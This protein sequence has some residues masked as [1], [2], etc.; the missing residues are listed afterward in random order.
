MRFFSCLLSLPVEVNR[1]RKRLTERA[2]L[3]HY[4]DVSR[5]QPV[6]D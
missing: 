5:R 4:G 6:S 3:S 2:G 1:T